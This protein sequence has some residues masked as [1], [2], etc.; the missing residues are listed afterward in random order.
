METVLLWQKSDCQ[1]HAIY[2][3]LREI[4]MRSPTVRQLQFCD[5][6]CYDTVNWISFT[7]FVTHHFHINAVLQRFK[8]K[9]DDLSGIK[10]TFSSCRLHWVGVNVKFISVLMW[11]EAI[12]SLKQPL[13]AHWI[14]SSRGLKNRHGVSNINHKPICLTLFL[15]LID[16]LKMNI[17]ASVNTL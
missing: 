4:N 9:R 6:T 17:S 5:K 15:F 8:F 11:L 2:F 7:L 16:W 12:I 13:F 3:N 14:Y 10:T 1:L